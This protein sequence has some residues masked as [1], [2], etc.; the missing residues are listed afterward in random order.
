HSPNILQWLWRNSVC[1]SAQRL[2]RRS[3]QA[4]RPLLFLQVKRA[5]LQSRPG[6]CSRR[7]RFS[8]SW[9]GIRCIGESMNMESNTHQRNQNASITKRQNPTSAIQRGGQGWH[10]G[11]EIESDSRG[12]EAGRGLFH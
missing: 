12:N 2:S 11:S 6:Y 3:K 1:R 10:G 5:G 7:F 9:P 8:F 4:D